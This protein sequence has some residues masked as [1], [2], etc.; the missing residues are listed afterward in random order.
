MAEVVDSI[1]A[2]LIARD[3][4]YIKT[5]NEATLAH[6][7]FTKSVPKIG[8]AMGISSADAQRYADRHTKASSSIADAEEKATT[9]IVRAK[10]AQSDAAKAAAAQEKQAAKDAESAVAA[11]ARGKVAAEKAAAA[12]IA[13]AQRD[14]ARET[15][16][17][18]RRYYAQGPKIFEAK[19]RQFSTQ[20]QL[21]DAQAAKAEADA[22]R[23]AEREKQTAARVTA[24]EQAQT[25]KAAAARAEVEKAASAA[26]IAAA[27][28]EA[29]ALARLAAVAERASASRA[30]P[31]STSGRIGATVRNEASGQRPIPASVMAGATADAAAEKEVNHIL[32]DRFDLQQR[33]KGATGAEKAAIQDQITYLQR[34]NTYKR[35]GLTEDEAI[36]RAEKEM[37]VVSNRRAAAEK[38]NANNGLSGFAR[39]AGLSRGTGAAAGLGL[40]AAVG[41]GIGVEVIASAVEYGKAL[42]NVSDQLGITVEDL[43]AYEKLARD[44]DVTTEQLTSAFGEFASNLGKAK[45][46][47]QEQ[48]KIFKALGIDI[49]NFASA[50]D[51]L[52]T[53]IDRISQIKDPAQRAAIE[54][55]LFGESGRRLD[56]LLSGGAARVGELAAALQATGRALSAREIQDLDQTARKLAE[57]K[58]QL[59]VDFA[60]IVAGNADAIATLANAFANV[61]D[62]ALKAVTAIKLFTQNKADPEK[63]LREARLLTPEGRQAALR[64]NSAAL[65]QN[66]RDQTTGGGITINGASAAGDPAFKAALAQKRRQILADRRSILEY[67]QA[68]TGATPTAPVQPGSYDPK[69]LRTLGAPNAPKGKSAETLASE[70]EQRTKRFNDA[71]QAAQ[72]DY[73]RAQEQ[74]TGDIEKRAAIELELAKTAY[75]NKLDDIDS[76]AKRDI[77]AGADQKLED[78]RTAELKAAEK[79]AYD[80]EVL[81]IK[82]EKDLDIQRSL[83]TA[84]QNILDVQ[85]ELLNSQLALATTA[86]DRRRIELAL[87]EN[88]KEQERNRLQGTISSSKPGDPAAAEAQR[89]LGTLD[90]R[91]GAQAQGVR[92]QNRG[93]LGDYLASLPKTAA[94]VDEAL[95]RVAVGSLQRINDGMAD[96][97]TKLTGIKG[98]AG[99]VLNALIKIGLQ[100]L[101]VAAF[102]DGSGGGGGLGGIASTIGSLFGGGS[103]LGSFSFAGGGSMTIG[104][105][106]GVDRNV[107]S[108]NGRKVANVGHG[109][110]LSVSPNAAAS[111]Q[112]AATSV[113]MGDVKNYNVTVNAENSV[114]PAG[115][116]A[117]LARQ[118]LAEA[119]RMDGHRQGQT[120]QAVPGRVGRA[121]T[122][123]S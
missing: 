100:M 20:D 13:K 73:L 24:K 70:A 65:R 74:L 108:L 62:K 88:A 94:E 85:G 5:F 118:I 56:S 50:G 95:E 26:A 22:F 35:A 15:E 106:T 43:Q 107:L 83:T 121:Q 17:Q 25:A 6:E 116:A 44:A 77:L 55:R 66:E 120:L 115:F 99:E 40:A 29:A 91:Y 21:R 28:R 104:G 33:L 53:V 23:A 58:A 110:V 72:A 61:A 63:G 57:V 42:K 54:T 2:E 102:G 98:E 111:N 46:G 32:A 38:R 10:K 78:A 48:S 79:K 37:L 122:L 3:N 41:V 87:L 81:S 86:K 117:G 84:A 68:P 30:I 97:L 18:Q 12:A 101:Q 1:I 8:G 93:P 47:G 105:K 34:I 71:L 96:W 4:G 27:D 113:R 67:G 114:T 11:A 49:K 92:A 19:A 76:Q 123:G 60:R 64:E 103:P 52:P 90:Q 75:Q 16:A 9:R 82:Q 31:Q 80:A 7:R 109:E 36:L 51:A 89:Q 69:A 14:V 119:D 39:G 45:Q 59:Q 112:R